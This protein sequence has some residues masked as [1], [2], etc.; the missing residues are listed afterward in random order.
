MKVGFIDICD[1]VFKGAGGND[2]EIVFVDISSNNGEAYTSINKKD[3]EKIIK[4][5]Q[6]VFK[7]KT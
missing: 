7:I 5:L 2:K 3:S 1:E 6:S 4:H